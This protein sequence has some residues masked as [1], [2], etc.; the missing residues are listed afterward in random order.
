MPKCTYHWRKVNAE[1][2]DVYVPVDA[3]IETTSRTFVFG[4]LESGDKLI[5]ASVEGERAS[6]GGGNRDEDDGGDRDVDGTAS[7][8]DVDSNRVEAALL[9]GDSQHANQS[10]RIQNNDLPVS[11]VPPISPAERPYGLIR[12]HRRGRMKIEPVNLKIEHISANPTQE[13]ETT[14]CRCARIVQPP[15]NNSK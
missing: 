11:S 7:G 13:G 5:A 2:T 6:E 15:G 10:R 3:P 1:D 14:Y 12:R 9:A 4:W 8:S